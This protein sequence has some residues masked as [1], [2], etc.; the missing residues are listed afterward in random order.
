M[1]GT[2]QDWNPAAQ[3][4][5]STS[6]W[7]SPCRPRAAR[8]AHSSVHVPSPDQK[9]HP[10]P[11]GT[12]RVREGLQGLRVHSSVS[13]M[14]TERAAKDFF[15]S[16]LYPRTF[17]QPRRLRVHSLMVKYDI[18][19]IN[20]LRWCARLR[21]IKHVL[22]VACPSVL[23]TSRP[24]RHLREKPCAHVLRAESRPPRHSC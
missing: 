2:E 7:D 8:S 3:V 17:L 11:P 22:S 23:F 13:A 21:G 9:A 12:R 10:F 15:I 4:H 16:L 19:A 6:G 20:R 18:K 1:L 14:S 24:W 5:Q